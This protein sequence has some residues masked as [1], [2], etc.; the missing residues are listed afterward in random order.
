MTYDHRRA[1]RALASPVVPVFQP[2]VDLPTST[3]VGYEALSRWPAEPDV[4]PLEVFDHA[5]SSGRIAELDWA[6]RRAAVVTSLREGLVRPLSVFINVEP[7]ALGTSPTWHFPGDRFREI[8]SND[9]QII[10]ELTER[11]V[12]ANPAAVMATIDW[13]RERDCGIALDD[14]GPNPESLALLP[15]ILPDVVKL[16]RRIITDPTAPG[17]DD[18][19]S[20]VIDYAAETG[21][22]ILAEGIEDEGDIAVA[23]AV[24]AT[25]GQGFLLGRPGI[26]P[27]DAPLADERRMIR[28]FTAGPPPLQAPVD[29]L[30]R[31]PTQVID[32]TTIMRVFDT[33]TS[34]GDQLITPGCMVVAVQNADAFQARFGHQ[35]AEFARKHTLVGVVGAGEFDVPGVRGPIGPNVGFP[36]QF[37]LAILTQNYA[38]TIVAR[39]LGDSGP[40]AQRRY[41]WYYTHDRSAVRDVARCITSRLA[42]RSSPTPVAAAPQA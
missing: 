9:L 21:A 25:L 22:R 23:R 34:L 28:P 11:D 8:T 32:Y 20:F 17:S 15:L 37:A 33:V 40:L 24:G 41:A 29:I 12:L 13:A 35:Y 16:D 10:I 19:I 30:D 5:R 4:S 27:A 42:P 6:C 3:I 39:D 31:L 38:A 14:V 2:I 1:E 18:T 36:R 7:T 26:P